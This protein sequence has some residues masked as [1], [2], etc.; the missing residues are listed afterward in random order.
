MRNIT[1]SICLIATLFFS[2]SLSLAAET[3][4]LIIFD[5]GHGQR[6]VIDGSGD[7][8]LSGLAAIM[9]D[10]GT[11]V[12]QTTVPLSEDT[13]RG[14]TSLVISGP[15]KALLPNEIEAVVRF[16]QNGGKL[17]VMLHIGLPMDGLLTSLNVDYSNSVLHERRNI[18]DKDLNF[19]V[20]DLTPH[21]VFSGI[22]SFSVYGAWALRPGHSTTGIARTSSEA[23]ID[24]N[25]DG[26]LSL[27]DASGAFDVVVTGTLGKGSFII[28]GDDAIFQNHFLDD[29]NRKMAINLAKWLTAH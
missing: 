13:L 12:T 11:Q 8:H 28:F 25:R 1:T 19:R 23:W 20:T 6:L 18:I 7:L 14:V 17:A 10:T 2:V 26:I 3:S 9:R 21:P 27:G 22:S 15:F 5:E 4:P 24:L 29:N 16:L